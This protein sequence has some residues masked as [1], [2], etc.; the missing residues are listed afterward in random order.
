MEALLVVR[1]E[2]RLGEERHVA[3]ARV[4][5][6]ARGARLPRGHGDVDAERHARPQPHV[7]DDVGADLR[8]RQ[9]AESRAPRPDTPGETRRTPTRRRSTA[10]VPA[11]PSAR[12]SSTRRGRR[13]AATCARRTGEAT[14]RSAR[15]PR[16]R[17]PARRGGRRRRSTPPCVGECR[18]SSACECARDRQLTGAA[19]GVAVTSGDDAA[20]RGA[21]SRRPSCRWRPCHRLIAPLRISP[22]SVR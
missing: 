22:M 8:A 6:V 14:D 9:G 20:S 17:S 5:H 19:S 1:H 12:G 15:P 10:G 2:R 3:E 21:S 16:G 11:S 7:R 4:G 13:A 18:R